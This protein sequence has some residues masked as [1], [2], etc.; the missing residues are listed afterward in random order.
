MKFSSWNAMKMPF[1]GLGTWNLRGH[2]CTSVVKMALDIGYRHIDTAAVY[3]NHTAIAKG[4]NQFPREQ[5]FLTSKLLAENVDPEHVE[6]GVEKEVSR[7][8]KELDVDYLDLY[9]I[10]WPDRSKP[11]PQ[12]FQ[13][14]A[15]EVETK[16]IRYIGVSNFTVHH[17]EDLIDAGC[18]MSANQVEFHPYLTQKPLYDFCK[19][20]DIQLISYRPL[21]KGALVEE[22]LFHQIGQKHRKSPA[23]VVLRWIVQKGVP[24]IPKASSEAHLKENFNIFDFS[25]SDKE[26]QEIEALNQ[27]RRFCRGDREEFN[28]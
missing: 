13:A 9:L 27:N 23:Q 20:E 2:E 22:P 8:L 19:G 10:H 4:I 11:L 6:K 28:Y 25:L 3:E 24:V 15:R 7:A 14:M 5:L 26:M 18:T 1:M 17:M 16:R 12:I 21:G